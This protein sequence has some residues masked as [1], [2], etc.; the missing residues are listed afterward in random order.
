MTDAAATRGGEEER[1]DRVEA[2]H[3]PATRIPDFFIVGHHKCGTTALYEMLRR[4]PQVYMPDVKE[5]WFFASDLI[6]R[7]PVST[8][9]TLEAYLALFAG[10]APGQRVGEATPSY[11][12]SRTAAADIAQLQPAARIIAI[13]REPSSFLRSLHLQALENSAET[14][15]DLRRALSLEQPRREGRAIPREA[16]RP[17]ELLYSDH[18]R[19]VEQLRRYHA[20]FGREQVLVL[21][22]EDFRKDNDA[23]LRQVL[24]FL[25]VEES[26]PITRVEANPT[27]R[28][29]SPRLERLI[30]AA[31]VG[32][33]PVSRITKAGVKALTPT[34]LR[35]DAHDKIRRR[36]LYGAPRL[37]DE[38]LMLELRSRFKGEVVALSE[39]L[40]RD[41]VSLW[42]YENVR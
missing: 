2:S 8:P 32:R 37:P 15:T 14:E 26:P 10:A 7:F 19:Y 33:G 36:V 29:R 11:L 13:F 30:R 22:Y 40:G 9:T 12:V 20:V 42:G 21:I 1:T 25:D 35:R 24:R 18:A 16:A 4:H 41:L 5:P 23:A 31:A 28:V 39:Y 27:V 38:E 34:Q 17:Q 6:A 3:P